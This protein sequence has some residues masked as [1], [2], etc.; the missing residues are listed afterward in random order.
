M[1]TDMMDVHNERLTD[2][3]SVHEKERNT[4]HKKSIKE[5]KRMDKKQGDVEHYLDDVVIALNQRHNV[6]ELETKTEYAGIKDEVRN[7]NLEDKQALQLN[8]EES[9]DS[10]WRKLQKMVLE[11]KTDT[12][13]KR[14]TYNELLSKDKKGVAE[15][16]E[17][18]TKI[19]KLMEDVGKLK[20]TLTEL[21]DSE[22]KRLSGLRQER[23]DLTKELH[24]TR[25]VVSID[26]RF[27]KI[28]LFC[29]CSLT[30]IRLS[31][32]T[33]PLERLSFY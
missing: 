7:R 31:F 9:M 18:N 16:A 4:L 33:K 12:E 30:K 20:E 13:E 32:K 22:E 10:Y 17:N 11:F 5:R 15:V 23:E 21:G 28:L 8:L 26:F 2:L 1:M 29:Y 24:D 25:R 3:V 27:A 14:R 6:L 19:Q